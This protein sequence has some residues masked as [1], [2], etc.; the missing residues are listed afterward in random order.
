[1]QSA[2]RLGR[3]RP[4]AITLALAVANL[5]GAVPVADTPVS[6]VEKFISR[7]LVDVDVQLDQIK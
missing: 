7:D 5:D 6:L 3:P 2:L 4:S 1:M